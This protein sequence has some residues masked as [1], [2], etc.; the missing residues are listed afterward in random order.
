MDDLNS[1]G[2]HCRNEKKELCKARTWSSRVYHETSFPAAKIKGGGD[3]RQNSWNTDTYASKKKRVCKCNNDA[4]P[5]MRR[6]GGPR[7]AEGRNL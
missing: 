5:L 2:R 3:A 4:E 7:R 6:R 1:E